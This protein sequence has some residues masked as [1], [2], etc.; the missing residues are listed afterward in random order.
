MPKLLKILLN[1]LLSFLILSPTFIFY[2]QTVEAAL[3]NC[4]ERGLKV[5]R[6]KA[7]YKDNDDIRF[8]VSL[9]ADGETK[10]NTTPND[11]FLLY[12]NI[13]K[14]IQIT[15]DAGPFNFNVN[16]GEL[17]RQTKLQRQDINIRATTFAIGEYEV[18][19]RKNGSDYCQATPNLIV[20]PAQL[21]EAKCEFHLPPNIRF[22]EGYPV[23]NFTISHV[24]GVEYKALL[25]EG[26]KKDNEFT[27]AQ[28]RDLFVKMGFVTETAAISAGAGA[29]GGFFA[30][31]PLFGV[32]AVPG[33]IG[34]AI[35][36]TTIGAGLGIANVIG[37][38]G[39]EDA[40]KLADNYIDFD[41]VN[42]KLEIKDNI[43]IR[44]DG[45]TLVVAAK[46]KGGWFNLR[47]P[48]NQYGTACYFDRFTVTTKPTEAA[49]PGRAAGPSSQDFATPSADLCKKKDCSKGGGEKCG[50][51]AEPAIRTAIGCIHTKP[52]EFVKDF[53][54]F[55]IGIAGGLAFLLM[56]SGAFQMI[57]SSGNPDTL[58][59]GQD[60]LTSA[61]IGL[62][63][64]IFAVL[65]LQIIGVNILGI[66]P[67]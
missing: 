10:Q 17:S 23:S 42:E 37:N 39:Y 64:I 41:E 20:A 26:A 31:L 48:G 56:L 62:M 11:S 38:D 7:L 57:T 5:V 29:A 14:S 53:M 19:I 32:G 18:K 6:D 55:T 9:T 54:K 47:G 60:R 27:L 51:D 59:S 15:G 52:Q 1:L 61:V 21:Q 25:Y 33:A 36:G 2:S 45:Y 30:G 66:F 35:V 58:K 12:T 49:T 63:L 40:L 46:L 13:N 50:T 28:E 65:L 34:G 8:T 22:G 4:N 16:T 3:K 24:P 67:P 44:L 43:P